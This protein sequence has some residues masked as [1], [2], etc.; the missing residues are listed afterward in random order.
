M[1]CLIKV[2]LTAK[3]SAIILAGGASTR[4]GADKRRLRLWGEAGP[5]LLEQM[6]ALG[7]AHCAECIVV[8]NDPEAWPDLQARPV[9]DEIPG[10]GPLGGL[11]SG[12]AAASHEYALLLACDMPLVRSALLQALLA[13]PR[14][15]DALVPL[16]TAADGPRNLAGAEPLLAIYRRTA[17][18]AVRA[19]LA[20]GDRRM[21][22]PLAQID[23]RFLTPEEWRPFDPDGVSF[24]NLNRP[25]DVALANR[26]R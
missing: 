5:T 24:I 9:R 22:A 15:F 3:T 13:Y 6:V 1:N 2:H 23:T 14:P 4:M 19:C 20:A 17:L 25:E 8:L 21:I 16:R 26:V 10:A 12:L 7:R 18:P 11:A